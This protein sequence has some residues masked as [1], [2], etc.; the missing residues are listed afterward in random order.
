MAQAASGVLSRQELGYIADL[1]A[2][3]ANEFSEQSCD[4]FIVEA[5]PA[6][7]QALAPV[8][9]AQVADY[10]DEWTG[11]REPLAYLDYIKSR[12]GYVI[13]HAW[14]A[15]FFA[16]KLGDKQLVAIANAEAAVVAALL[17][18]I[19]EMHEIWA[20]NDPEEGVDCFALPPSLA[21]DAFMAA[22]RAHAGKAAR[23]LPPLEVPDAMVMRYLAHR[24][25][26]LAATG[27]A[28]AVENEPAVTA[29][30]EQGIPLIERPGIA[31]R[32][33][34]VARFLEKYH[35]VFGD[36]QFYDERQ[37]AQYAEQGPGF[38]YQDGPPS[39]S[40]DDDAPDSQLYQNHTALD[41]V[42]RC[43]I[44]L[45]W[46]A[47][48]VALGAGVPKRIKSRGVAACIK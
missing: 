34:T 33:P 37:L 14:A 23:T 31:P 43:A 29:L 35:G 22:V 17:D 24:L 44:M 39:D 27:A 46:N 18:A 4:E 36:W 26:A 32:F 11:P 15:A 30:N 20:E 21:N 1:L 13:P 47:I 7:R 16:E 40:D 3:G 45:R 41:Q 6:A 10:G 42:E 5:T 2:T 8:I 28:L 9:A 12:H 48:Q 19:A 25:T 38:L